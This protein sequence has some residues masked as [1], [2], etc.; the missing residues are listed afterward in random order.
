MFARG[1]AG[2]GDAP[3][4][5]R[6]AP[7]AI[8]I[9]VMKMLVIDD[10]KAMRGFLRGLA[11]E[12]EFVSEEAE[13]GRAALDILIKN[14]PRDP[15]DVALVDLNM[16]RMNG[17][18]FIQFVRRNREYN[19]VK[20]MVVTT[21]NSMET[22]ASAIEAGADDL[23]MKPVTMESLTEKLTILGLVA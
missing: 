8:P 2:A 20:L 9:R 1:K 23:L 19:N 10:S 17:I 13:D 21:E 3:A 15:F 16:P 5:V 22:L 6:A 11:N 4:F 12:L 7:G 14:D 18:E